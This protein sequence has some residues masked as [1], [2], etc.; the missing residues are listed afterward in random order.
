MCQASILRMLGCSSEDSRAFLRVARLAVAALCCLALPVAAAPPPLVSDTFTNAKPH[1]MIGDPLNGLQTEVGGRTWSATAG[2]GFGT[3]IFTNISTANSHIAGVAFLPSDYPDRTSV[4]VEA[5]VDPTDS[6]WM[7]V[8]LASSLPSDYGTYGQVWAQLRPNGRLFVKAKGAALT[9]YTGPVPD[10][11]YTPGF[12]HLKLEYNWAEHR[13][14]VWLNG[15]PIA[16]DTPDLDD[17]GWTPTVTCAGLEAYRSSAYPSTGLVRIDDFKVTLGEPRIADTFANLSPD[18]DPGDPLTGAVTE[19]GAR[20]WQANSAAGFGS[21]VLTNLTGGSPAPIGGFPFSPTELPGYT[22]ATVTADLDPAGSSWLGV[23]F[24]SDATG[25]YWN[26]GQVWVFLTYDGKLRVKANGTAINI[27]QTGTS[28]PSFH[29]GVNQIRL[30]YSWADMMVRVWLNGHSIQ[31]TSPSLEVTGFV[32]SISFVGFHGFGY[33]EPGQMILD[34]LSL[35]ASDQPAPEVAL[36]ASDFP[37]SESAGTVAVTAVLSAPCEWP[38]TVDW[39]TGSGSATPDTDFTP[40]SGTLTWSL[41][42]SGAKSFEVTIFDDAMDEDAETFAV[43]LSG[44]TNAVLGTQISGLV[45]IEDDDDPP[46]LSFVE[47]LSSFSEGGGEALVWVSLSAASSHQV[48]VSFATADGTAT[49]GADY[50]TT[51]GQLLW[52]PGDAAPKTIPVSILQ[53][54][55]VEGDETFSVTLSGATNATIG[56]PNPLSVTIADDDVPTVSFTQL[57]FAGAEDGPAVV[58][59]AR[60]SE[61][62]SGVARISYATADDTATAGEDYLA[63]S[64]L[65]EWQPT[66]DLTKTFTVGLLDDDDREGAEEAKLTLSDPEGLSLGARSEVPLIVRD[67]ETRDDPGWRAE[68]QGFINTASADWAFVPFQQDYRVGGECVSPVV[69]VNVVRIALAAT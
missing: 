26:D 14:R 12:N 34:D 20:T 21:G 56:A 6:N 69:I 40:A 64:G 5:V 28:E 1:R 48:T 30:E 42:E 27:Y 47:P 4:T 3:N 32:P 54:E 68:A 24:A 53:D 67:D 7:A 50:G 65:L 49:A 22:A 31:L 52:E 13:V 66:D 43:A 46:V 25:A 62:P 17:L 39:A 57:G 63:T 2:A 11:A 45:S 37:V 44:P 19:I 33:T 61:H 15:V 58:V 8:G 51:S 23:G 38:V 10:P 41:G 55:L 18:R 9:L 36:S 59:A 29:P 60:L 16:L 35:T